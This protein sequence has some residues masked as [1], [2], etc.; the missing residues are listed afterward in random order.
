MAFQNFQGIN[1]YGK[2][3]VANLTYPSDLF[4]Q[5]N[6]SRYGDSWVMFN[7][8][9]QSFGRDAGTEKTMWLDEAEDAKRDIVQTV[10]RDRG[11]TPEEARSRSGARAAAISVFKDLTGD[12]VGDFGATVVNAG[13]AYV[14]TSA[15]VG[16]LAAY[17]GQATRNTKRLAAAIQLPMPNLMMA[18]YG[19]NWGSSDTMIYDM[20]TRGYDFPDL[21]PNNTLDQNITN[22]KN[23]PIGDALAGGV[24]GI[25]KF[26]D[27]GGLSAATGLAANTKLEQVFQGMG[28]REFGFMYQFFPKSRQE[29]D[30]IRNIVY[31]F[32]YHAHPEYKNQSSRM[33]FIYP[34]EFDITYFASGGK[35]NQYVPRV[36]TCILTSITVNYSPQNVWNA[37]EDGIPNLMNVQMQF[38]ELGILTKES[39]RQGF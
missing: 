32:K 8:N 20:M 9:V 14:F 1:N 5:D 37:H 7:I 26:L 16:G 28:F 6:A 13:Q 34:S 31:M 19:M 33:N 22:L 38:K 11:N 23:A 30:A 29:A 3:D 10:N 2:Y 17:A 21:S 15:L 12:R 39:I 27:M 18:Q 4:S 24:L 25:S 36:A 35:E